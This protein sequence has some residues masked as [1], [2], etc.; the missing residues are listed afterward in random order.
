MKV[1]LSIDQFYSL[2]STVQNQLSILYFH[3]FQSTLLAPGFVLKITSKF[4][5]LLEYMDTDRIY[6]SYR[7]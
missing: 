7:L 6:E 2:L 5:G 3:H 1:S 4:F